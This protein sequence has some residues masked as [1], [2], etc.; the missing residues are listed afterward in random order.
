MHDFEFMLISIGEK[1]ENEKPF[2]RNLIPFWKMYTQEFDA[3]NC[4]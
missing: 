2:R 1:M 4:S 3:V